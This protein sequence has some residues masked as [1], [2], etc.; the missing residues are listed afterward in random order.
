VSDEI[1]ADLIEL[2][3]QFY[4]AET[5]LARLSGTMPS[6]TEIAGGAEADPADRAR[7]TA[8]HDRLGELAVQIQRHPALAALD[9]VGR[10]KLDA[11]ASRA[12]RQV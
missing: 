5:E 11:A 4:A 9:P 8:T 3:Q 10:L 1:P 2:K 7:W 12:A 6:S